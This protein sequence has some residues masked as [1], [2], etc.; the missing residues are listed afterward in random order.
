MD[1]VK[2][3]K[4]N[5]ITRVAKELF[6]DPLIASGIDIKLIASVLQDK[7]F[8]EYDDEIEVAEIIS[9]DDKITIICDS[10]KVKNIEVTIDASNCF[11]NKSEY[12]KKKDYVE[13]TIKSIFLEQACNKIIN[14]R[15]GRVRVIEIMRK[16]LKKAGI[17]YGDITIDENRMVIKTFLPHLETIITF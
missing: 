2:L 5:R 17:E 3:V 16:G 7:V 15:L 8:K 1:I 11:S 12:D 10:G 13:A 9:F 6:N 4:I 14:D